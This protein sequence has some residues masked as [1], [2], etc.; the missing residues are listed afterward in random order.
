MF[1]LRIVV[2]ALV[3]FVLL[4][5][6]CS[7]YRDEVWKFL[8]QPQIL[9]ILAILAFIFMFIPLPLPCGVCN[10]YGE[11]T[12]TLLRAVSTQCIQCQEGRGIYFTTVWKYVNH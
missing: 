4:S 6:L 12:I 9:A 7:R 3:F 8:G 5:L 10:A 1:G 2:I 11:N